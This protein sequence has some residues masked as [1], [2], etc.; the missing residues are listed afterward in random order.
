MP[1]LNQSLYARERLLA[2]GDRPLP[3]ALRSAINRHC[4]REALELESTMRETIL[5]QAKAMLSDGH[6]VD[7]VL[8]AL[9]VRANDLHDPR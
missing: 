2:Q 1:D 8:A 4:H 7:D 6:I 5:T 3:K 9:G